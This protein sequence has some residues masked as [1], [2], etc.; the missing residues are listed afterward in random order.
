MSLILLQAVQTGTAGESMGYL[1]EM[2]RLG[3]GVEVNYKTALS[4]YEKS[5]ARKHW[6][7]T[8]GLGVLHLNGYGVPLSYAKAFSVRQ[9]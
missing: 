5:S 3:R 1:G 4:W 8:H 9:P 6:L 2:Y 7:G